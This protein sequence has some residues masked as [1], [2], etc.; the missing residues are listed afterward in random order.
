MIRV[1]SC[2]C[3][4]REGR[5]FVHITLHIQ[6]GAVHAA[7][8]RSQCL[9]AAAAADPFVLR[10]THFRRAIS[11]TFCGCA[12]QRRCRGRQGRATYT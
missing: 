8:A 9:P 10:V 11:L 2:P 1:S 6:S 3:A 4:L 7:S 12:L 5:A